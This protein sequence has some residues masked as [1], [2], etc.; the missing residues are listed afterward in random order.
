MRFLRIPIDES[1]A[2]RMPDSIIEELNERERAQRDERRE[3]PRLE[4][5]RYDEA[6]V[7]RVER[8]RRD[9]PTVPLPG[10]TVIVIDL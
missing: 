6:A 10:S 3:A 5:P 8:E 9:E 7:E 2:R 1:D 4:M